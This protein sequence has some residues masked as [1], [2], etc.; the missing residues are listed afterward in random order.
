M[1]SRAQ[2]QG[3]QFWQTKSVAIIT[4]DIVPGDC[5]PRVIS[6]NGD[7][8][9][10]ESL[11]TPRPAPKVTLKSKWLVQQQQQQQQQSICKEDVKS[12][13]KEVATWE[14]RVGTRDETR[15]ATGVEKA[16][17]NSWRTASKMVVG[18]DPSGQE[19]TA[20]L[21]LNKMKRIRKKSTECKLVGTKFC[22]REDLAKDKMTFSEE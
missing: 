19:V 18:A 10:F 6:Q 21:L 8:V 15:D 4:H 17:G 1:F 9:L 20:D 12:N 13:S 2:D 3:L 22:F 16:S 5:I 7:R 14:S 11:A